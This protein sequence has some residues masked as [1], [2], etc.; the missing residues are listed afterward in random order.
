MCYS[1][2]IVQVQIPVQNTLKWAWQDRYT[3]VRGLVD[4]NHFVLQPHFDR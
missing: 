4:G 3:C 1:R 2:G